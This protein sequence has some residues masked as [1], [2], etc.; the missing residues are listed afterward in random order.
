LK[1]DREKAGSKMRP[2]TMSDD[3]RGDTREKKEK[4]KSH[5]EKN[6]SRPA[7]NDLTMGAK[8]AGGRGKGQSEKKAQNAERRALRSGNTTHL[9]K[10][11]HLSRTHRVKRRGE[12]EDTTRESGWK[13]RCEEKAGGAHSPLTMLPAGAKK[14]FGEG[15]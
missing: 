9:P 15:C 13:K 3:K 6:N 12:K 1:R 11:G 4:G 8:E 14:C 10:R 5:K 7:L 2:G